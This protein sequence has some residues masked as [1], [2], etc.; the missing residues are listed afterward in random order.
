VTF[1]RVLALDVGERRIGVAVSDPLQV[2]ARSL[3]VIKRKRLEDDLAILAGLVEDL[4][5]ETVLVG[6]PRTLRGEVGQQARL[7]DAFVEVL[8]QVIDAP[9]VLWDE[10]LSTVSASRV[11]EE[12]GLDAREQR[13]R[14][15]ATAAAIILQAYLDGRALP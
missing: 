9:V 10:W 6:Y 3:Q 2:L 15:D 4:E 5:V 14:I 12:Q 8:K 1:M 11:L 7:V 13:S